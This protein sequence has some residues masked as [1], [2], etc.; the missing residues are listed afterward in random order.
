MRASARSCSHIAF[1]TGPARNADAEQRR[2]GFRAGIRALPKGRFSK[3]MPVE[4]G[5][6]E[7][8]IITLQDVFLMDYGPGFDERGR[9]RGMLR[10]AAS[11][12][13]AA[14]KGVTATV[15]LLLYPAGFLVVTLF[16]FNFIGDGLRDALDPKDR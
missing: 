6:M 2:R 16:C 13:P 5:G 12:S 15:W 14:L 11:R 7:G 1:I 9:F 3:S 8:E 10:V 4:I